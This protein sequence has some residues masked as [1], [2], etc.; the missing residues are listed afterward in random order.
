M[1]TMNCIMSPSILDVESNRELGRVKKKWFQGR[2]WRAKIGKRG[3][4]KACF[5]Y[6]GGRGWSAL[7]LGWWR[8]ARIFC[9]LLLALSYLNAWKDFVRLE[10]WK[11]TMLS[12]RVILC[13]AAPT[14]HRKGRSLTGY[15]R[16]RVLENRVL[17]LAKNSKW[18]IGPNTNLFWNGFQIWAASY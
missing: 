13:T 3:G 2:G 8:V 16:D 7:G 11:K 4:E 5:V 15:I 17:Q 12:S 14:R 6:V 9:P 1:R 10:G 18:R